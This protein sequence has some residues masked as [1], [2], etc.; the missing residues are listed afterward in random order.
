MAFYDTGLDFAE[1][2]AALIDP[3]AEPGAHYMA[4]AQQCHA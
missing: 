4:R 1:R 3:D 2:L